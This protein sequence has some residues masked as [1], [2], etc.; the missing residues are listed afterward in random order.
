[1]IVGVLIT[2]HTQY[3]KLKII[4]PT[5]QKVVQ[6]VELFVLIYFK[7]YMFRNTAI[8]RPTYIKHQ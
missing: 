7:G 4:H 6:Q 3:N 8:F 5:Q 1:M 2:C